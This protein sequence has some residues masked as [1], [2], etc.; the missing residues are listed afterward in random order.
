MVSISSCIRPAPPA[1]RNIV[2]GRLTT[3]PGCDR[4]RPHPRKAFISGNERLNLYFDGAIDAL[5]SSGPVH[6]DY[7]V[8]DPS[9]VDCQARRSRAP[10]RLSRPPVAHSSRKKLII[11][12][13]TSDA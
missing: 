11:A 5:W 2:D 7:K 6:N 8:S 9:G 13:L 10:R 12:T 4:L 1:V 3:N